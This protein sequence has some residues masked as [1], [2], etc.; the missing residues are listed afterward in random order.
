MNR[1]SPLSVGGTWNFACRSSDAWLTRIVRKNSAVG[2]KTMNSSFGCLVPSG[3]SRLSKP[4][5]SFR[6]W[7]G[8]PSAVRDDRCRHDSWPSRC[9]FVPVAA[10]RSVPMPAALLAASPAPWKTLGRKAGPPLLVN[11]SARPMDG[12]G[13]ERNMYWTRSRKSHRLAVPRPR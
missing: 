8:L 11:W 12:G 5:P 1:S 7:I 6:T 3:T 4:G 9:S 10:S 2:T 13:L